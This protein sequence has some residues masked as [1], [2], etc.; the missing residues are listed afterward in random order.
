MA[1]ESSLPQFAAGPTTPIGQLINPGGMPVAPK[2]AASGLL[3]R[4][5]AVAKPA[6]KLKAKATRKSHIGKPGRRGIEANNKVKFGSYPRF[7]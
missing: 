2:K 5:M 4:I 3:K 6:P 7:Y 1:D